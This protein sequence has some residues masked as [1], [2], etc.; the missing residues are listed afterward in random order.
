MG[1]VLTVLGTATIAMAM[2]ASSASAIDTIVV[3]RALWSAVDGSAH[4][5]ATS[6]LSEACDG[7][8]A[9]EVGRVPLSAMIGDPSPGTPKQLEVI[10]ACSGSGDLESRS[11]IFYEVPEI[12][13]ADVA[14]NC[15]STF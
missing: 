9:C 7:M 4:E 14:L 12:G 15:T 13:A 5:D 3:T 8:E 2:T 6:L 10:Y 11:I 1:K